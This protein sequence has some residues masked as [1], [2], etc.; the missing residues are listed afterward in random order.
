M[1]TEWIE[2]LNQIGVLDK[3]SVHIKAV[4]YLLALRHMTECTYD[5]YSFDEDE[6]YEQ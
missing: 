5:D 1:I 6:A 4:V 3:D 2:T